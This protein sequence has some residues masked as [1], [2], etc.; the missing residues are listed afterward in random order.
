MR[1]VS[2]LFIPK[3]ISN[4][5]AGNI[6]IRYGATGPCISVTTA[7]ASSSSAIGEA[8][9]AIKHGYAKAIITGGAE[10]AINPFAIA[11]FGNAQTLSTATDK[12]VASVPFDKRRSGFVMGDGAGALILE[13][14]E[15]ALGA[16]REDIRRGLRLRLDLRRLPHDRAEPRG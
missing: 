7:C 5:A 3:M 14:Y 9:R 2:P 16:R 6:A 1:K 11:G 10:A 12:N 13:E 15:H 4:I 8:Y